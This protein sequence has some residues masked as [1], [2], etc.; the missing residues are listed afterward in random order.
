MNASL[1]RENVWQAV[2]RTPQS[3]YDGYFRCWKLFRVSLGLPVFLLAGAGVTRTCARCWRPSHT[4][5]STIPSHLAAELFF[6]RPEREFDLLLRH[7][8]IVDASRGVARSHLD[9]GTPSPVHRPITRSVLLAGESFRGRWVPGGRVL[10]LAL[11][12]SFFYLR[13]WVKFSQARKDAGTKDR[14]RVRGGVVAFRRE[15]SAR[16]DN[17]APRQSR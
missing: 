1:G 15:Y 13:G 6:H 14:F 3:F 17:V 16:M 12:A 4:L 8:W 11:G 2:V 7:P 9:A 10:W 5:V